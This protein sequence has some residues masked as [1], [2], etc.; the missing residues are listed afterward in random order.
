MWQT[1]RILRSFRPLLQRSV[2]WGAISLLDCTACLPSLAVPARAKSK[3]LYMLL[4][5][6]HPKFPLAFPL[7]TSILPLPSI[8]FHAMQT[9]DIMNFWNTY[10]HLVGQL[11]SE[12]YFE[13]LK[14]FPRREVA[15]EV[16]LHYFIELLDVIFKYFEKRGYFIV[17]FAFF[18][19]VH[20]NQIFSH[21]C[22]D[23]L[24]NQPVNC[25]WRSRLRFNKVIDRVI[26]KVIKHSRV[27]HLDCLCLK[28]IFLR[29]SAIFLNLFD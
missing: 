29:F 25:Q 4:E 5:Y 20:V 21:V 23:S 7:I 26:S 12:K 16:R 2:P 18:I 28:E 17:E 10:K 15:L 8:G 22:S 19:V 6:V 24:I 13:D 9:I 14:W 27:L 3:L 11:A 1:S